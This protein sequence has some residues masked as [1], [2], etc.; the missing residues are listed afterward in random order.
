MKKVLYLGTDPSSFAHEFPILHYPVI[1]LIPKSITDERLVFCFSRIEKFSHFLFTSK[2]AVDIFFA[3]CRQ[4]SLPAEK[5]LCKKCI[6]I[7]PVT[8][9]AL[10]D[11]G[12]SPLLEASVSTQ[13]GVIERLSERSW[14]SWYLFYP[15]SSLARPL[16]SQ[17]LLENAIPHEVL[18][19]YDT[20]PQVLY[21]IPDL[22]DVKEIVFTSPSTIDGFFQIFKEVPKGIKVSFQGPITEK[23]FMHR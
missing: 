11:R 4:F 22:Q 12:V 16:L 7:G 14:G 20:V 15:R 17:Y 5:L 1:R 19:L 21:P 3:I 8:S 13:E 6:S 2:N 9:K 10:D 18:D 23:A